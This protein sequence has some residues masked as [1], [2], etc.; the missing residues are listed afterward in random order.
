MNDKEKINELY[1]KY[2]A[3][4]KA[5]YMR[6]LKLT[7]DEFNDSSFDITAK[8]HANNLAVSTYKV[9]CEVKNGK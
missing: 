6:S 3:N 7:E 4:C 9:L 8:I 1:N 5:E 2:Y